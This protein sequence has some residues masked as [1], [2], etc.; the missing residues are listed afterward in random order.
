MSP[1]VCAVHA[2][3]KKKFHT[4]KLD[5]V[6]VT[7]YQTNETFRYSVRITD[8]H[9]FRVAITGWCFVLVYHIDELKA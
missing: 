3:S 4:N 2:L 8:E 9:A 5:T 1:A 7:K 6:L